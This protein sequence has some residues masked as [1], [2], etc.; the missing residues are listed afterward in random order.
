[1][2]SC[3][4]YLVDCHFLFVFTERLCRKPYL[5]SQKAQK[6]PKQPNESQNGKKSPK[7]PAF[8]KK[9]QNLNIN[10][11]LPPCPPRNWLVFC[12]II[13]EYNIRYFIVKEILQGF[14][15]TFT[16]YGK[17]GL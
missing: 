15:D 9:W 13:S 1:M 8:V 7:I 12:Y 10:P 16:N 3:T 14:V 11:L 4:T 17:S 2:K 6:C 5:C